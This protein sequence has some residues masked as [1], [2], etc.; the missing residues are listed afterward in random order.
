VITYEEGK[1]CFQIVIVYKL[2]LQKLAEI[3]KLQNA[4]KPL[5][6]QN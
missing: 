3:R 2:V 6:H 5:L 1:L 4:K